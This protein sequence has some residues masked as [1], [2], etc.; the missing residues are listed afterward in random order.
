MS[1]LLDFTSTKRNAKTPRLFGALFMPKKLS[2]RQKEMVYLTF[3]K[4][5]VAFPK[6]DIK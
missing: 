1:E 4:L 6:L 3:L 2:L 5:K